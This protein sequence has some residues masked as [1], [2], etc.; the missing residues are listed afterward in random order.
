MLVG[1]MG[2]RMTTVLVGGWLLTDHVAGFGSFQ[3]LAPWLVVFY[4]FCL[5]I[6]I[7]LVLR[8]RKAPVMRTSR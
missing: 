7:G 2:L 8:D 4:L 1:G 6:E 3:K 5:A